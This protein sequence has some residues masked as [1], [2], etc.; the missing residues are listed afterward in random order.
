MQMDKHKNHRAICQGYGGKA[1]PKVFQIIRYDMY[2]MDCNKH[3]TA[4]A[5]GVVVLQSLKSRIRNKVKWREPLAA[6][7]DDLPFS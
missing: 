7:D 5:G 2:C 6:V 3:Y 1:E 4:Y